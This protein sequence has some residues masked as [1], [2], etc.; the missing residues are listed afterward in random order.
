V[1]L[2]R[3]GEHVSA[4]EFLKVGALIMPVSLVLAVAALFI[5]R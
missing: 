4:L 5:G 3:E 1:A 2:R